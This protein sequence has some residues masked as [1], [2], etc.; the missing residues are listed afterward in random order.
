M[1][2]LLPTL[3]RIEK[4]RYCLMTMKKQDTTTPGLIIVDKKDWLK[5]EAEYLKL[6]DECWPTACDVSDDDDIGVT[7]E[8]GWD[9][10]VT[11]AVTMGDKVREVWPQVESNSW[12]GILND[13]FEFNTYQWD[14]KLLKRLDGK[15]F[16]SSNDRWLAPVR[17][18]TATAWS[19]PLLKAV[20]FPIFPPD[21][22]HLHIDS[23]WEN[24]G[25]ATGCWRIAMDVIV[26][27]RHVLKGYDDDATNKATYGS[28]FDAQRKGIKPIEDQIFDKFMAEN[29]NKLVQKIKEFQD[30]LPGEQYNPD[31][32]KLQN[33]ATV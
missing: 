19:M 20:G 28:Y 29:F 31:R 2:W 24:L 33:A 7:I 3:G 32:K 21:I 4:L 14:S 6:K 8:Q 13:D 30:Y 16:V 22:Q 12:L 26:E 1:A 23:L 5:N 11:E 25:R 18:T 10:V 17:A 15:N 27:H 9:F